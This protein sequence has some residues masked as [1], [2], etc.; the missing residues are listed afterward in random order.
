MKRR[1]RWIIAVAVTVAL[2]MALLH[3]CQASNAL[4]NV[5]GQRD[6]S[7][8]TEQLEPL[9]SVPESTEAAA[10]ELPEIS[11]EST[12]ST[13]RIQDT[14]APTETQIET[15]PETEATS[16]AATEPKPTEPKPTEPKPT[17]PAPKPTEPKPT[18]PAPTPTEP[19]P[20]EPKPTEPKPTEPKPT[21]PT[22]TNPPH[23]HSWGAWK[24]TKAPTCTTAGEENR[25]C[26]CGATET[27]IA[28]ALGHN[29][30]SWK[31]NKAPTCG[32]EGTETSTC[33]RCGYAETRTIPATGNHTWEETAPTC[34]QAG[35]KTCKVC[36]KSET[37][38]ALG[39]DWVH[40]DEG[41]EYRPVI[42]CNC[43][44]RFIGKPGDD[45]EAGAAWNAHSDENWGNGTCGGFEEHEE[46]FVTK[47][48]YDK[49][50]RCGITKQ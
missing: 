3:G 7:R 36:G 2:L 23:T 34:T 47:P 8:T 20:T 19:K 10:T 28:Y 43:G 14:E 15:E 39:H 32:A 5:P 9:A 17:E 12:L 46:W 18:E 37:I 44:M 13:E 24:Q 49:C 30:S 33:S 50:S 42:T 21:E 26:S 41:G 27:R 35:A 40:H 4:L 6:E 16:E 38:A 1:T 29:M 31:Q 48:A 45:S 11:T 25:T 22:P